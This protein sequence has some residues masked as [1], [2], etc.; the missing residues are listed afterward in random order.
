MYY[1]NRP[2]D[3][4]SAFDSGPYNPIAMPF[5]RRYVQPALPMHRRYVEPAA[6]QQRQFL[7]QFFTVTRRSTVFELA[8]F[9]VTP[10]CS[11]PS[12]IYQCPVD[13]KKTNNRKNVA[14]LK[15]EP[16]DF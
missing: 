10:T 12:R 8:F 16:F 14:Q 6:G 4:E 13:K 1:G 9:T 3:I 11:E 2:E 7:Q 15:R 5:N